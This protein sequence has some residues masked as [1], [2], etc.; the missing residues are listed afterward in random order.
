[1]RHQPCQSALCVLFSPSARSPGHFAAT[2][3]SL[4]LGI[5]HWYE[6]GGLSLEDGHD[7]RRQLRAADVQ[8]RRFRVYAHTPGF[9]Q[10]QHRLAGF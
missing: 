8:I 5:I 3:A 4:L 6:T 9:S 7:P 1:M 2:T 10:I